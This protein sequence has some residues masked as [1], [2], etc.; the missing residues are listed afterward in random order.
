MHLNCVYVGNVVYSAL[1]TY[2]FLLEKLAESSPLL[3]EKNDFPR[4]KSFQNKFFGSCILPGIGLSPPPL[5]PK[6]CSAWLLL[7]LLFDAK[8]GKDVEQDEIMERI[9]PIK[10]INLGNIFQRNFQN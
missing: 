6:P 8:N 7:L 10:T 1:N 4:V 2:L 9:I 3:C 5:L